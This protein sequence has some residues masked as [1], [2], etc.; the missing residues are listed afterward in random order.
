M[1]I[2]TLHHMEWSMC[3]E[4][5]E[6]GPRIFVAAPLIGDCRTAEKHT[7]GAQRPGRAGVTRIAVRSDRS[8][9]RVYRPI[10][11][12]QQTGQITNFHQYID[13]RR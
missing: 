3:I 1:V 2:A 7:S 9:P 5:S 13:R 6:M 12:L 4:R 10:A 11:D 8:G